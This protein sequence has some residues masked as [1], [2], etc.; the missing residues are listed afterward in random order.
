M[1]TAQLKEQWAALQEFDFSTLDFENVGAWPNPAK[2]VAAIFVFI[3]VAFGGYKFAIEDVIKQL[4]NAER[5][6]GEL[7]QEFEI[8]AFKAAN[9][10]L[11]KDQ[12]AEMERTFG[13]LLGQLPTDTEV[14]GL[15]EDI[16]NRGEASNLNF[17]SIRLLEEQKKEFYIELPIA[18]TAQ[19]NYH[20]MGGFV[21]GVAA[22]PRIVTLHDFSIVPD[23]KSPTSLKLEILGKTYRY[24][25]D[26]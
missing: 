9:L 3:V 1:N 7:R 12:L 24:K 17:S 13:E 23:G 14:P 10:P 11:L 22:L 8:K 2:I 4:E 25:E 20:D 15:L 19:G 26:E 16:S 6:E 18:I 21:S 5:K